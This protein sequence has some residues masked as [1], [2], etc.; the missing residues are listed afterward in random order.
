[1]NGPAGLKPP[2]TGQTYLRAI[3]K[4]GYKAGQVNL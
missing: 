3:S 1:M 4:A 2:R